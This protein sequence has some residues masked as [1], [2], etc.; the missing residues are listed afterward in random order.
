[1]DPMTGKVQNDKQKKRAKSGLTPFVY[2]LS[3]FTF[4]MS[5]SEYLV[6]RPSE[7]DTIRI[8]RMVCLQ[9]VPEIFRER[10]ERDPESYSERSKRPL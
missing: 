4:F 9:S 6:V 5:S 7:D 3:L 10:V 1:M 8:S 2:H